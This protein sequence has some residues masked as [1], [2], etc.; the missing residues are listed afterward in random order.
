MLDAV[1][2]TLMV[3]HREAHQWVLCGQGPW[4]TYCGG[5]YDGGVADWDECL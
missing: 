2:D 3:D 1:F 5:V 4:E